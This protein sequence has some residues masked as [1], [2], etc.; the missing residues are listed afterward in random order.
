MSAENEKIQAWEN[1]AVPYHLLIILPW[2][3]SYLCTPY[4][5]I[6][7]VVGR[8]PT[9]HSLRV[10]PHPYPIFSILR[11]KTVLSNKKQ[12]PLPARPD[13]SLLIVM[14]VLSAG[15]GKQSQDIKFGY[16]TKWRCFFHCQS[17]FFSL[18]LSLSLP[19]VFIHLVF[20]LVLWGCIHDSGKRP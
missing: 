14:T 3:L 19:P 8:V 2:R 20:L 11:K 16:L 18:S 9:L 5:T 13:V 15:A 4:L 17:H 12:L 6:S 7:L 1:P 10:P